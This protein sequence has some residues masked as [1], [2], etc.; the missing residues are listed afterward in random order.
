[1]RN[2]PAEP[3]NTSQVNTPRNVSLDE[4]ENTTLLLDRYRQ[5]AI[6]DVFGGH[7]L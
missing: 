1:M 6:I 4:A 7:T 5:Y 2:N 3:V